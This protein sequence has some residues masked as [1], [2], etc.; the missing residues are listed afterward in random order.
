MLINSIGI[1]SEP[2][3]SDYVNS[4]R[5]DAPASGNDGGLPFNAL[6]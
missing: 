2:I 1:N 6:P 5:S 3:R 4:N